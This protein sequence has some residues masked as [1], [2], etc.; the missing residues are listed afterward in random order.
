MQTKLER[1]ARIAKE[2]PKERFT[3]LVH[4]INEESLVQAHRQMKAKKAPG[5]DKVTKDQ[6]EENLTENVRGLVFPR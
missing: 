4:L 1:I 2:R 3:S 6:Y 5:L